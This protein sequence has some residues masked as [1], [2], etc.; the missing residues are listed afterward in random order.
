MIVPKMTGTVVLASHLNQMKHASEAREGLVMDLILIMIVIVTL[1]VEQARCSP[2]CTP[3]RAVIIIVIICR[4]WM[5]SPFFHTFQH[6]FQ[7]RRICIHIVWFLS[8]DFSPIH[9]H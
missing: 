6:K 5:N 7:S 4:I 8:L 2:K 9:S 1:I 3:I